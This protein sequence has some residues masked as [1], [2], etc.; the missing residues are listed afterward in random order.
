MIAACLER[1]PD[2]ETPGWLLLL[3]VVLAWGGYGLLLGE[4]RRARAGRVRAVL[5]G[6]LAQSRQHGGADDRELDQDAEHGDQTGR[7]QD[8][9]EGKGKP[10]GVDGG[11]GPRVSGGVW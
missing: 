8:E 5:V 6:V 7:G 3:F 4:R 9:G 1:V 11:H 10:G 2:L